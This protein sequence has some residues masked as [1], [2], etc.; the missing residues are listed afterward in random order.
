MEYRRKI[1]RIIAM[2]L[3]V[4][5]I[6]TNGTAVSGVVYASDNGEENTVSDNDVSGNTQIPEEQTFQASEE[7]EVLEDAAQRG[8]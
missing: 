5:L 8:I 1:Q 2:V 7:P 4:S 3:A 6:L